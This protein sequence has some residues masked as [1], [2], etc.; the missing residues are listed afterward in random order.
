MKSNPYTSGY[1]ELLMRELSRTNMD[2]VAHCVGNDKD[3]FAGLMDIVLYGKPPVVQRAAW[4]MTACLEKYPYLIDP[5]V[6]L[7][8]ERLPILKP[9]G[10][11]RQVVKA[12]SGLDIPEV[13]QGTLADICFEWLQSAE[14]Q[15]AVKVHCMQ[16]L[17]NL[18]TQYPD[19]ATELQVAIR[20][21]IPRNSVAFASR[22]K[23]IL[24]LLEKKDSS[25]V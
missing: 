17:A 21:Q 9:D 2:Y 16:I 1:S 19:L 6:G 14:I 10:V 4:A 11:K 8:I 12:L 5:Y 3:S 13:A 7:L 23:K 25:S 22:A 15:V 20:E 18:V 24:S